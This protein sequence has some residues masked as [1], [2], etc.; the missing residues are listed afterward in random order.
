[1]MVE[2]MVINI[3]TRKTN[4][5]KILECLATRD[6]PITTTDLARETGID[7][8]NISRYLK[9]LER[10]NKIKREVVQVGRIRLVKVS[11]TTRK[12]KIIVATK[13]RKS[14]ESNDTTRISD[15]TTRN[16]TT[17]DFKIDSTR[18]FRKTRFKDEEILRELFKNHRNLIKG[19]KYYLNAWKSR[20]ERYKK[21]KPENF[22]IDEYESMKKTLEFLYEIKERL[23]KS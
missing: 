23:E 13:E 4:K 14:L 20:Y 19:V 7:I 8:K 21:T 3:T 1:M 17:I 6:G 22:L 11:L 12:E 18:N 10:E 2:E 5:E 9:Q 15:I 16:K